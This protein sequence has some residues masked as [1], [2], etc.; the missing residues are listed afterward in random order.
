LTSSKNTVTFDSAKGTATFND[1]L[2][3]QKGMYLIFINVKTAGSNDYNF[4]CISTPVTVKGSA[5]ALKSAENDA[6]NMYLTF[7][8]NFT[9]HKGNL[10]H[11]E[12]MLY[13]CIFVKHGL[14]MD[15]S[16]TLYQGSIKAVFSSSGSRSSFRDLITTLN[17]FTLAT[18]VVLLSGTIL[19]Q[20]YNFSK[21]DSSSVIDSNTIAQKQAEAEKQ[22]AV[23]IDFFFHF[24]QV[25]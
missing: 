10:K 1:L 6:P 17:N 3:D 12:S 5:Q 20:D 7:S 24:F 4:N 21:S 14:T 23:W 13:N 11:Y 16:I 18:D 8:G 2:I 25:F 9:Q 22:N 15:R 19:N